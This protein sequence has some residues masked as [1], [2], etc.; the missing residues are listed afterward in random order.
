LPPRMIEIDHDK[1][2]YLRDSTM[3]GTAMQACF[4]DENTG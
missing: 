3:N 4:M 1:Q 2:K